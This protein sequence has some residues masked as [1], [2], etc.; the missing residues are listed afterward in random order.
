M[1]AAHDLFDDAVEWLRL[2]YG[3]F[4]FFAERDLVWTLQTRMRREIDDRG[5]PLRVYN[6]YPVLLGTRRARSADLVLLDGD[7]VALAVEMKYEPSHARTDI[8]QGKL[9][10]VFWGVEGVAKDIGRV[11]EFVASGRVDRAISMFVDEGGA[12]RHRPPHPGS[13]WIDWSVEG[14][15]WLRP[16]LLWSEAPDQDAA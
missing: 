16:S 13:R 6:D 7:E 9:P 5:L 8:L 12:F 1:S 14:P 2:G 15:D 3:E 4:V 11:R 10:V